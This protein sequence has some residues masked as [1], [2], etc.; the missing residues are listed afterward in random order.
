MAK[1]QQADY[2]VKIEINGE[3]HT[4]KIQ[5]GFRGDTGNRKLLL[6]LTSKDLPPTYVVLGDKKA[7][8]DFIGKVVTW[9][10]RQ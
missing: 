5:M 2:P 10:G 6:K 7:A 4:G 8:H 9:L 1:R 3:E